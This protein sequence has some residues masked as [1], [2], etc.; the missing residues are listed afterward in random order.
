VSP[1]LSDGEKEKRILEGEK[2]PTRILLLPSHEHGEKK[3]KKG[4]YREEQP[5]STFICIP[6][7][8]LSS[9]TPEGRR[10]KK[11]TRKRKRRDQTVAVPQPTSSSFS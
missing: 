8:V 2:N 3:K 11:G 4:V 5:M 6:P 9:F 7:L 1:T 10:K